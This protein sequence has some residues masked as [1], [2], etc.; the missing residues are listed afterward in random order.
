M[1]EVENQVTN[2][3]IHNNIF[4]DYHGSRGNAVTQPVHAGGSVSVHDNVIWNTGDILIGNAQNNIINMPDH[5]LTDYVNEGYGCNISNTYVPENVCTPHHHDDSCDSSGCDSNSTCDLN[6]N[7]TVEAP[8]ESITYLLGI[9][10]KQ[11]QNDYEL[12]GEML[13]S[14]SNDLALA[15]TL[16]NNTVNE[17]E[18]TGKLIAESQLKEQFAKDLFNLSTSNVDFARKLLNNSTNN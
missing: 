16:T 12:S 6:S 15:S 11:S 7:S 10:L 17:K 5:N 3:D 18:Y 13:N 1:L 9:S 2:L 14:S 4:Y 8:I